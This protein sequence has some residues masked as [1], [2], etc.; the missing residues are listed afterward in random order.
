MKAE[1][2]RI[3]KVFASG[4]DIHYILPYFQREY[5][6]EKQN[7]KTLFNDVI[8]V[9]ES[10]SP[11]NEPEHFMGSLV[12]INDGTRNGTV[13]AFKLVDGQQRLTTI[14][15]VFCALRKLTEEL[16]PNLRVKIQKLLINPEEDGLLRYKL[17]PTAK[18]GDRDVYLALL[19]ETTG[20][21]P[22]ND[23]KIPEAFKFFYDE[24]EKRIEAGDLELEKLFVV[25]NNCLQVVFI[26][27]N[28]DERPY[29]IFESLNYKGKTLSQADLVRNYI[30]MKLPESRQGYIFE[31]HWAVVEDLLQEKRTVGRS[32]LGELTA[33]LRHYLAFRTGILVNEGHVY[34]RF[35]D[36]IEKEFKTSSSFEDEVATLKR[37]SEYYNKLLRPTHEKDSIIRF[38]LERLNVLEVSTAY[39]FLLAAYEALSQGLI[40]QSDFITGLQI[41]EN[42]IVRRYI[43]GEPTNYTNKMFP[44]LWKEITPNNF[45]IT[46]RQAIIN[47]NYPPDHRIRQATLSEQLYDKRS[48]SRAKLSLV[49]ESINRHL[50]SKEKKGGYT[51]LDGEPTI[52]HIMPQT[53]DA[54]WKEELGTNWEQTYIDFL[55]TIGNLT[56]V[57]QEWN[58]ELSNS[59]YI[60]KKQKLAIHALQL[61]NSYFSQSIPS[62]DEHAIRNRAEWTAT[63]ILEIWASLGTSTSIPA[64][65]TRPVKLTIVGQPFTV[66]SWRDVAYYTAIAINELVDNFDKIAEQYPAYFD[67]SAFKHASRQLPNGWWL[68]VNLSAASVKSFCRNLLNS[69]GISEDE[70]AVEESV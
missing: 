27:L 64:N 12:V 1:S 37:F 46:L 68:Y 17:L 57:T 7:W 14:S 28:Q 47:K 59:A 69:A 67:K 56:L 15:L 30:A 26:D 40:S 3:S 62:W 8:A 36:R 25:L 50:S 41:L 11:T 10:Y 53:L 34:A 18:Y 20:P 29:E 13:P 35:R 66:S 58:S 61:N 54:G 21:L 31:N 52:E 6:W 65:S 70:W 39:P 38:Y 48:E 33:F 32:R 51:V 63:Q 16:K 22:K 45:V 55:N 42:Y 2:L 43:V 60:L 23:S 49:L 24:L 5:A 9:Y 4:G 19:E 44:V